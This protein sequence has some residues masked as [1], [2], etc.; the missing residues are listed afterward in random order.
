MKSHC[1]L[2]EKDAG[3]QD[4]SELRHAYV[5]EII[6]KLLLWNISRK[7]F[8]IIQSQLDTEYWVCT[9][10]RKNLLFIIEID[11]GFYIFSSSKTGVEYLSERVELIDWISM[12][13][14]KISSSSRFTTSSSQILAY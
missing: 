11:V 8:K 7:S 2:D 13:I 12:V 14:I 6:K 10:N 9:L 5:I 4:A 3:S 1:E